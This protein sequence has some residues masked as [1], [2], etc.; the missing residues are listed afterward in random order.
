P[1]NRCTALVGRSGSNG[2]ACAVQYT[3]SDSMVA[4]PVADVGNA[5][6]L[7]TKHAAIGKRG[8]HTC[9]YCFY[10]EKGSVFRSVNGP[11]NIF[12]DPFV[13]FRIVLETT[14]RINVF[15]SLFKSGSFTEFYH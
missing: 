6:A 14:N 1:L 5:P 7:S 9:L 15:L 13:H 8:K 2:T 4:P 11:N 10:Y 12:N 3:F